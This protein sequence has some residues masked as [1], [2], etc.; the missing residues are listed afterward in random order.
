MRYLLPIVAMCMMMSGLQ[1]QAQYTKKS[2]TKEPLV[3]FSGVV[4]ANDS[5]QPLFYT[6]II[7]MNT[8]RG[9]IS[10]LQ[11]YF[12]FVVRE[13][14]TIR[15]SAVGYEAAYVAIPK[16]TEN[17]TFSL[18]QFMSPD[19]VQLATVEVRAYPLPEDFKQAFMELEIEE[20][21]DFAK[22][23]ENLNRESMKLAEQI[24]AYDGN[25]NYDYQMRQYSQSL[26][27]NGQ[28]PAIQL[29]NAFAWA[30]FIRAF[31]RGDFKDKYKE[32]RKAR[33]KGSFL[34]PPE[35]NSN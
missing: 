11:G 1:V 6:T 34:P 10:N 5:I 29:F 31:K 21:Q 3:Q 15:F 16:N 19:T 4:M 20:E 9:T 32:A 33:P 7:D 12:S 27:T 18:I 23:K 14:D 25:E 30:D 22:A 2:D 17:Q 8:R 13:G 26:Y 35:E 24:M 28:Y